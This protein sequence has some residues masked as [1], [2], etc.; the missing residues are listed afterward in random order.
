M[1]FFVGGQM[2]LAAVVVPVGRRSGDRESL[3][4]IARRFGYGT[5]VALLVLVATGTA[6]A[7][8]STCGATSPSTSSWRSSWPWGH[9]ITKPLEGL[10]N[11]ESEPITTSHTCSTGR[12]SWRAQ[13]TAPAL[14]TAALA[15]A[16]NYHGWTNQGGHILMAVAVGG[17]QL[18]DLE[19]SAVYGCP[20]DH[21]VHL[22][23]SFL[24]PTEPWALEGFGT[25]TVGLAGHNYS[26]RVDGTFGL[27][28]SAPAFG[29]LE[30]STTTGW[31]GGY[32][33]AHS[34]GGA[35]GFHALVTPPPWRLRRPA[36]SSSARHTASAHS[37]SVCESSF[38]HLSLS[39]S[40]WAG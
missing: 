18:T 5:L 33:G 35:P 29:T 40:S 6:M 24:G 27:G 30:A 25:F 12:V 3:R 8:I 22:T 37:V 38:H 32:F 23:E 36:S 10:S 7:S 39:A 14:A 20:H 21:R 28:T 2:M 26:G 17:R 4:L 16:G 11:D 15:S 34:G 31:F 19:F 9:S 1:A 13:R